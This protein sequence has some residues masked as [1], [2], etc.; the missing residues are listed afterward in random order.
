MDEMMQRDLEAAAF[1]TDS[2]T[3]CGSAVTCGT[4]SLWN[5]PAFVEIAS[6]IGTKMLPLLKAYHLARSRRER[7]SMACLTRLGSRF[8][9]E[10]T[11]KP[12]KH[13]G[14]AG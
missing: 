5:L 1:R 2:S 11:A 13:S 6:P 9:T 4:S 12:H 3:I 7:S 10:I 8:Q 14:S